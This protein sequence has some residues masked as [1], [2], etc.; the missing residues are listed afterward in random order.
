MPHFIVGAVGT[1]LPRSLGGSGPMKHQERGVSVHRDD[2]SRRDF[3]FSVWVDILFAFG[4][5]SQVRLQKAT[6]H[7]R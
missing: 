1:T 4:L 3:L 5:V 7:T 6:S 2:V